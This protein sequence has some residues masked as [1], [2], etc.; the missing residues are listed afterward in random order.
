MRIFNPI[1]VLVILSLSLGACNRTK[2]QENV[3]V[4]DANLGESSNG[5]GANSSGLGTDGGT[6]GSGLG[7]AGGDGDP[8]SKRVV[9]F[10]YDSSSL[11]AESQ[12]IVEAHA[13]Y[14]LSNSGVSLVLEGHADER[15]TREYNLALGEDRAKSV[16]KLM[17]AMGVQ[18]GSVRA[19]SYG[20]ERPVAL[21]QDES[22]WGLNRRVEI[23]YG[24]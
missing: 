2:V 11:T 20:E 17:Q 22:A 10:D 5:S 15:G 8:L 4:D 3:D 19:V 12:L 13:N 14:M 6:S 16:A 9:Y 24:N 18:A 1:L 21:G 23:L 7:L